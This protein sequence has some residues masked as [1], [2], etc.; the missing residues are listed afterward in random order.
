[1]K[2]LLIN[3]YATLTGGAEVAMQVLRDGLQQRGH[4]VRILASSAGAID[5][6]SLADYECFG[7]MSCF[8]TLLQTTNLWAAY[9][10]RQVLHE[11]R[12]DIVH[13]K[14]F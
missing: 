5:G 6:T 7:T 14:I 10:L 4:E 12:P 2:I 9:R 13:V 1:M 8:R 11:F 3:D